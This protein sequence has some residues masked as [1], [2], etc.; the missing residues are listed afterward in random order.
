M[1]P[2]H[3]LQYS[4]KLSLDAQLEHNMQSSLSFLR[5]PIKTVIEYVGN[6]HKVLFSALAAAATLFEM[7]VGGGAAAAVITVALAAVGLDMAPATVVVVV[8][9]AAAVVS[10]AVEAAAGV[11]PLR[12]P[13]PPAT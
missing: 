5:F 13:L 3:S 8:V 11:I 9:A 2:L 12:F 4:S 1:T 7:P 6:S 10:I